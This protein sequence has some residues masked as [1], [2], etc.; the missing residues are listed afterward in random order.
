MLYTGILFMSERKRNCQIGII[1]VLVFD[2]IVGEKALLW[3]NN[4]VHSA[5][6]Q[7]MI[8]NKDILADL[9]LFPM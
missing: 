1:T 9:M 8:R 5:E 6:L 3:K 4:E 2:V 7:Y